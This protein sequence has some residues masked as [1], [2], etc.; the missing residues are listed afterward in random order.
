MIKS[1]LLG[2]FILRTDGAAPL[3]GPVLAR[4]EGELYLLAFSDRPRALAARARLGVPDAA[5]FYVCLANREELVRELHATGARGF[6]T[7]YDPG[8]STFAAAG[9]LHHAA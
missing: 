2:H 5:P 8:S 4:I 1:S 7:D 9:S 3:G 6:I